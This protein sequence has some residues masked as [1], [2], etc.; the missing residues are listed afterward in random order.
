[1][2]CQKSKQGQERESAIYQTTCQTDT[3][4]EKV[5]ASL[6]LDITPVSDEAIDCVW[7]EMESGTD[8]EKNTVNSKL[9]IESGTSS[10]DE[11]RESAAAHYDETRRDITICLKAQADKANVSGPNQ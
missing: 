6:C 9:E 8:H 11:E 4:L 2:S 1:M 5:N 7:F 3:S 10:M